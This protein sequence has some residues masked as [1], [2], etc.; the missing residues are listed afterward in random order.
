M[1]KVDQASDHN[2]ND[3][4]NDGKDYQDR[5][6]AWFARA[7]KS[8]RSYT[9][10]G[11]TRSKSAEKAGH[12]QDNLPYSKPIS[13]SDKIKAI[14]VSENA[15]SAEAVAALEDVLHHLKNNQ[16]PN[17]K[18]DNFEK[19]APGSYLGWNSQ[20][21]PG[22]LLPEEAPKLYQR[23]KKEGQNAIEF[24]DDVWGQYLRAGVLYL[25][26]LRR[27]DSALVNAVYGRCKTDKL[28]AREVLPPSR[29]TRLEHLSPE[30][31]LQRQRE[32]TRNQMRALREQRYSEA[33]SPRNVPS[34]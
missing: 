32:Q 16:V 8:D 21:D 26:H 6:E 24:L 27:A 22:V 10:R 17:S 28:S 31:R 7:G 11:P 30:E 4:V 29:I 3:P 34:P 2:I 20:P 18:E 23:D 25:D 19:P 1:H 12:Q 13:L 33:R 15:S 9:T 5:L 14:I